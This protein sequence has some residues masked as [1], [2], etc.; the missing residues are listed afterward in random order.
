MSYN[1]VKVL[2]G[3]IILGL[4]INAPNILELTLAIFIQI[5]MITLSRYYAV[6]MSKKAEI[7][8][9]QTTKE[10]QRDGM[11]KLYFP[12]NFKRVQ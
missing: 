3:N 9:F 10:G 1:K 12:I 6:D 2:R 4:S 8:K 5:Q 11:S 7:N